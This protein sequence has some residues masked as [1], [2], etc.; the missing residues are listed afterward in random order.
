MQT[1]HQDIVNVGGLADCMSGRKLKF[2]SK[3]SVEVVFQKD[4][5]GGKNQHLAY[6]LK[7][8]LVYFLYVIDLLKK[9]YKD[10][11]SKYAETSAF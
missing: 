2:T 6:C 3:M 7:K 5:K 11:F 1:L 9:R 10:L 8:Y 4:I